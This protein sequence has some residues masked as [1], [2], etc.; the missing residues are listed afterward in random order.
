MADAEI[1]MNFS[2]EHVHAPASFLALPSVM[3]FYQTLVKFTARRDMQVWVVPYGALNTDV[4]APQVG[5]TVH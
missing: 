3:T 5:P 4:G 1:S 2:Q